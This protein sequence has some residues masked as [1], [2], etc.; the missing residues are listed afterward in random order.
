MGLEPDNV[1]AGGVNTRAGGGVITFGGVIAEAS[2]VGGEDSTSETE[3]DATIG[4]SSTRDRLT[5][6]A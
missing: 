4:A 2:T 5:D 6:E 1:V 3:F